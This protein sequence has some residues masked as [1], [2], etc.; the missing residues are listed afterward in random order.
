[1]ILGYTFPFILN[2]SYVLYGGYGQSHLFCFTSQNNKGK[3][4]GI[5]HFVYV[6]FIQLVS[7]VLSLILIR[8]IYLVKKRLKEEV[9]LEFERTES[10]S[11][12]LSTSSLIK[13]IIVFPIAQI[14]FMVLPI[15]YRFREWFSDE[16]KQILVIYAGIVAIVCVLP[17][18]VYPFIFALITNLFSVI[19]NKTSFEGNYRADDDNS[20]TGRVSN[21]NN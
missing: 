10:F 3:I 5:I 8:F 13:K 2:L 9:S 16:D 20:F 15:Y 19:K 6:T 7:F 21:L 1:M 4:C 18:L 14:L 12:E 17:A 11:D